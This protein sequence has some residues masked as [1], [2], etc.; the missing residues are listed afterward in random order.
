M[1]RT[2]G[3]KV[4][5]LPFTGDK[6]VRAQEPAAAWNQ[7]KVLLPKNKTWVD[8]FLSELLSFTG[9]Q[10]AHD[11]QVDAFVSAFLALNQRPANAF[12]LD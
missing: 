7:G 3:A 9:V 2:Q 11:D 6:F 10:D 4:T 12:Y 5:L 1:V 8:P